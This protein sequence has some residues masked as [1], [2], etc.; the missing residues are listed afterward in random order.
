[1]CAHKQARDYGRSARNLYLTSVTSC[2]FVF[3]FIGAGPIVGRLW[4]GRAVENADDY[5]L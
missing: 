3:A 1:M 5:E 2:A 4:I